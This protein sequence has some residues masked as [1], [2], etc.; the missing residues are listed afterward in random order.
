MLKRSIQE[1]D[2][3]VVF[4]KTEP[5][6]KGPRTEC[7]QTCSIC[8]DGFGGG[9]KGTALPCNHRIHVLCKAN[10]EEQRGEWSD[11]CPECRKPFLPLCRFKSVFSRP[12]TPAY[13]VS[14]EIRI[15]RWLHPGSLEALGSEPASYANLQGEAEGAAN[16]QL[17]SA[18]APEEEDEA[19]M[20]AD[21]YATLQ[22]GMEGAC[23]PDSDDE[24]EGACCPDDEP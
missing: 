15:T 18:P 3:E 21:S 2:D 14:V 11:K 20:Y 10:L 1:V 23:A 6:C 17:E 12:P 7:D 19:S 8:L 9:D 16:E 4:V 22:E 5:P 13:G 24:V